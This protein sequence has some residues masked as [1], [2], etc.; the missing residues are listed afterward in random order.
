LKKAK[1]KGLIVNLSCVD[2]PIKALELI[3]D[4]V[5]TVITN[6]F[7]SVSKKVKGNKND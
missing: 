1:E 7:L 4:G 3:G 6:N 2:D 5:N